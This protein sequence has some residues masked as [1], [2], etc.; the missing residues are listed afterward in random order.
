MNP[1][2]AVLVPCY[3]RPEY[4]AKC[5]R[6][7]VCNSR[8]RPLILWLVDDGSGDGTL[9]QLRSAQWVLACMAT[10]GVQVEV[11]AH[12]KNLGLRAT[13]LEFW[14][15]MR[16][17]ADFLAK[18]DNDSIVPPG[19]IA[20]MLAVFDDCPELEVLSPDNEP[21][22]AALSHG[23][24]DGG[25]YRRASNMGGLWFM[26]AST[27]EKYFNL[28]RLR[29]SRKSY[30]GGIRGAWDLMLKLKRAGAVMGWT[31]DVVIGDM[32]HWRGQH[33]QH[34]KSEA[35]AAYSRE[36]GRSRIAWEAR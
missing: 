18:I 30:G 13:I 15:E 27:R 31:T 12:E 29:K 10:P 1:R 6:S 7:L 32:G 2:V 14:W 25:R 28:K 21:S 33:P 3:K 22:H 36:V 11:V 4:T 16:G 24:D 35:H 23:V 34:I 8:H 20:K 19:W 17:K 9:K 5:V 26:R